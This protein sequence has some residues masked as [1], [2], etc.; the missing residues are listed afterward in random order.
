MSGF[1]YIMSNPSFSNGLLKIGKST[2]NPS[3]RKDELDSTG[4]PEPFKIEYF[5]LV[6]DHDATELLIHKKLKDF[7]PHNR[8]EFFNCSVPQA[9]LTIQEN[10]VIIEPD[11]VYQSPEKIEKE[12]RKQAEEKIK[13]RRL[14]EENKRQELKER[15]EEYKRRLRQQE[16]DRKQWEK[17]KGEF[18]DVAI[19]LVKIAALGGSWL[20]L[21]YLCE[22]FG[23]KDTQWILLLLLVFYTIFVVYVFRR[24]S[25]KEETKPKTSKLDKHVRR[26]IEA[27][28][29]GKVIVRCP[30]CHARLRILKGKQGTVKCPKCGKISR[31]RK[32]QSKSM[33]LAEL[34]LEQIKNNK[35]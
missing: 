31:S 18:K 14:E 7:R 19:Y 28:I 13:Q 11:T 35:R 21:I 10:A 27:E 15:E 17:K 26:R 23:T 4:V 32:E 24:I 6:E 33:D 30:A 1:I 22:I 5:V 3:F 2:R 20:A 34:Y 12:K 16:I 29:V 9:I 25:N 8:R